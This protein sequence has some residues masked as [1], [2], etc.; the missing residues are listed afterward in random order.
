MKTYSIILG[1]LYTADSQESARLNFENT[2]SKAASICEV[3]TTRSLNLLDKI[4]LINVLIIPLF[5][6]RLAVSRLLTKAQIVEYKK[7]IRK[8]LWTEGKP[9]IA[10][11]KLV[12]EYQYGGLKLIDL[13][14]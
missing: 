4:C 13:E 1:M 2:L 6:Y 12:A 11:K 7:L 14:K 9:Q 8:F 3:W 5:T 10:Y